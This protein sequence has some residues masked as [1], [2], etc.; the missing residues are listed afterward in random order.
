MRYPLHFYLFCTYSF[1]YST[2]YL[3]VFSI[4]PF[5]CMCLRAFFLREIVFTW[6]WCFGHLL[7]VDHSTMVLVLDVPPPFDVTTLATP[8]WL[9]W[10]RLML[11][12]SFN[13]IFLFP[14]SDI[15]C[16]PVGS[17]SFHPLLTWPA[18]F[19]IGRYAYANFHLNRSNASSC[20]LHF[21]QGHL[22]WPREVVFFPVLG[23]LAVNAFDLRDIM[24]VYAS[25]DLKS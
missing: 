17:G 23:F 16:S 13:V 19:L 7:F 20:S 25:G 22:F 18:C 15:D 1:F 21:V 10:I 11:H 14:I 4:F 2:W 12:S 8:T 5:P 3:L 9:L 24:R 6:F